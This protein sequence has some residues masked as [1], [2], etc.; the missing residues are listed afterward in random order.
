MGNNMNL[1]EFLGLPEKDQCPYCN[2]V[3]DTGFKDFDIEMSSG[4]F[5]N[6]R[7]SLPVYCPTAE[8][9]YIFDTIIIFPFVNRRKV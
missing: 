3:H 4:M 8:Q 5:N 1:V 2:T 7:I 6:G 9:S